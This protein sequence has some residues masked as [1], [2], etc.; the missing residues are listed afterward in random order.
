M[1]I[2]SPKLKCHVTKFPQAFIQRDDEKLSKKQKEMLSQLAKA[3]EDVRMGHVRSIA[4]V[5]RHKKDRGNN[6]QALLATHTHDDTYLMA[7]FLQVWAD[8]QMLHDVEE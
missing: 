6:C 5:K 1:T 4:I 8:S 3:E 7:R 2:Q